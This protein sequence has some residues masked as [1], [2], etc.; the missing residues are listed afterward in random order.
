MSRRAQITGALIGLALVMTACSHTTGPSHTSAP[1]N[2]AGTHSGT[3][4]T[5]P[6]R[7]TSTTTRPT[8][9]SST[10]PT[11]APVSA[12]G[13]LITR[14]QPAGAYT[15]SLPAT[16]QFANNS[17]PSDHQTN[18]WSD[19]SDADSSLTVVLSGCEGCVKA[20]PTS[21]TPDPSGVLPAGATVTRTVQPWQIFY[22]DTAPSSGYTDFGS[23][24]VTHNGTAVTGYAKV[25]LVIPTSESAAANA[26]L[27]SFTL[28]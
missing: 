2:P 19:P 9:P 8:T 3:T 10:Q 28:G 20:A 16:W 26:V 11:T 7:T 5:A 27:G 4:S 1:H 17:V 15:V 14:P 21:P 24:L 25:D 13:P 6:K 22:T 23:I 12:L 18:T